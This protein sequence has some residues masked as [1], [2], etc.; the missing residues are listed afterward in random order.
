M[1]AESSLGS[2]PWD[3]GHVPA[4]PTIASGGTM[5]PVVPVRGGAA[6]CSARTVHLHVGVHS[7]NHH[8]SHSSI[9]ERAAIARVTNVPG[10]YS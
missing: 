8:R 7:Y 2:V 5:A 1:L 10:D 4:T 3:M 6:A 9:G